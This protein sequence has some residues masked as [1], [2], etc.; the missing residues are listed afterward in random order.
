MG[1][2][3]SEILSIIEKAEKRTRITLP[4]FFDNGWTTENEKRVYWNIVTFI[5]CKPNIQ[6][7]ADAAEFVENYISEGL[8]NEESIN[9]WI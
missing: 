2:N 8:K 9:W 5:V 7:Y 3:E 4:I 6:N 1:G